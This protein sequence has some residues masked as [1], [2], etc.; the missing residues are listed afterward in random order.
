MKYL[1]SAIFII[2]AVI[3]FYLF[4]HNL[5]SK[6]RPDFENH[7]L[8]YF[9][10]ASGIWSIGFGL[11]FIQT[12]VENAYIC[13]SVAVFGT[14][15]Y[16]ITVQ[17][18]I[19]RI[20]QISF[21]ASLIFDG[22][23]LLGFIPYL[24]SIQR[25]QTKYFIS[26]FGMTYQFKPGIVNN[27]YT[28]YFI[29]VSANILGV[30]IYMI[31]KSPLK[32]IRRFGKMFLIVTI[33]VLLGTVLDM[34]FPAL[35][36]PA[37]PGSNITQFL[38]LIIIYYAMDI[39]NKNKINVENM[40]QYIYFSL[41]MPVLVFDTDNVLRIS[42]EAANKFFDMPGNEE[43]T[44]RISVEN[45]FEKVDSSVFEFEGNHRSVDTDSLKK[46]IACNL[47]ISKINDTYGDVLGYIFIVA[48]RSE[49]VKYIKELEIARKQ[50]DSSNEAKSRFL[51]NM[52]HEI[53]TPMNAI[54]GFSELALKED[55]SDTLKNYL[56]DI[57]SSSHNLLTLINDILD[58]SKI[59]SGKMNLVDMEYDTADLLNGVY[60]M[61]KTQA[62]QKKIDFT[63]EIDSNMPKTLLGDST[64]I[65][66][67]LVNLLNNAV[68]Y[69][70]EGY[71]RFEAKVVSK[72]DSRI[73]IQF[74]VKDSGIGIRKENYD[75]L[76]S[77]FTQLDQSKNYGIE[78]NG[79]GLSMVKGYCEMM[80]GSVWLE[81]E[82]KK[83]STFYAEIVQQVLDDT[84]LD[85]N[86]INESKDEFSFGNMKARNTSVLVVDDN[87]VNRRVIKQSMLFYGMDV[88]LAESGQESIDKCRDKAY[89]IVFMDQMMPE[90]DGIEAMNNIRLLNEHYASGGTCK[91]IALTANAISG[92]REQLLACGFDEYLSKPVN[93]KELENVLAKLLPSDKLY[94]DNAENETDE[95]KSNN[96]EMNTAQINTAE[97]V[98]DEE[99]L[100][101]VY[102]SGNEQLANML[103]A[104]EKH[105]YLDFATY[106][107]AIKG[108]CL[109]IKE[110]ELAEEAKALERAG[111]EEDS[112]YIDNNTDLFVEHYRAFL[113]EVSKRLGKDKAKESDFDVNTFA[114]SIKEA[115]DSFD[116]ATV[117]TIIRKAKKSSKDEKSKEIIEH[118]EK[119]L[120]E[121]QLE[122]MEKYIGLLGGLKSV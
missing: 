6:R 121:M 18:L 107:H 36:Y 98:I 57:K 17:M 50:A 84:P 118:V 29:L 89:D 104:K 114:Q 64:R 1:F 25:E 99:L 68:K 48:D 7:V 10:L 30:I 62:S 16:M 63:M 119:L 93:F 79:L 21:K 116:F 2:D 120:D 76:F 78:G 20:S 37:L 19:C 80:S 74:V 81:S 54:I 28:G 111:K 33:L 113:D 100:Q 38:G 4:I 83:G 60:Q 106:A 94:Y 101:L 15:A 91:I 115:M 95:A 8:Q 24:L 72:Y 92:V 46:H 52:S 49:R 47:T 102:D 73:R 45:L 34:V 117:S 31:T 105:S 96:V 5:W 56:S 108:T 9:T 41:A 71:V 87:A 53:R 75:K 22:I 23:A 55:C 3:A 110:E 27:I 90:M 112:S 51:A 59:E 40:S 82:Y 66:S 69:T 109:N 26:Q 44:K 32:R 13:R 61:I 122:E 35:G 67:I 86:H 58:I 97:V 65:R 12:D 11:L 88:E 85:L 43:R 103:D 42:N 70:H 14:V 77:P 39:I